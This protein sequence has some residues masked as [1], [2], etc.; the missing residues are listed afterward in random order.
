MEAEDVGGVHVKYLH[1]CRRQL[2]LFSRG[3]RPER[4]SAL[5]QFGEAVHETRYDRYREVDL[6]AARLD[7]VDGEGWVH[8]VKS[9]RV[10]T[11]AD[12]AQVIHY[13]YR[14]ETLGVPVS[15]GVQHYPATRRTVRTRYDD[16]CRARAVADIAA[17]LDTVAMQAAPSRID[18]ERCSGCAFI[19]YCWSE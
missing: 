2:W 16:Q 7:S 1:H 8:E 11:E 3:F 9:S 10:P 15:G 19:E 6:G 17:V 5:V 12:L 13:C 4:H 14:L 18:R